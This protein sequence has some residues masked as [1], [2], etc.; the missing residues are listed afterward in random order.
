MRK[1]IIFTMLALICSIGAVAQN[2]VNGK[3]VTYIQLMGYQKMLSHKVRVVVDLGQDNWRYQ[4]K[5]RDEKG[6]PIP[7]NSMVEVLN[8]MTKRGWEYVNSY[9]VTVTNQNVY[10]FL[11]KKY[12]ANEEE[13]KEGLNLERDDD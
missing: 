12:V 11:L 13:I 10:H 3:K 4:F 5:L 6:K 2:E 1:A 8:Y 7:F 9:P